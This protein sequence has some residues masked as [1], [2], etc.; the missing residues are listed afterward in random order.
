MDKKSEVTRLLVAWSDGDEAAFDRLM[1]V[2]EDELRK[3]ARRQMAGERADHTLETMALVNEM[4]LRLLDRRSLT[5]KNSAQFRA[6]AANT[7]KRVL[8]D[9][10]RR[11]QARMRNEGVKPLPI[12]E[13]RGI[14]AYRNG[15]LIELADGLHRLARVNERQ[16]QVIELHYF[17][18]LTCA[19]IGED[20]GFSKATA[21]RALTAGRAWLRRE[22][23]PQ[24]PA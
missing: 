6:F 13:I 7:M 23:R 21:K 18:G 8:V 17:G 16:A 19:Q 5:W 24:E 20:L 10:A 9:H 14:P 4:C 11:Y 22:M 1:V 2:L 15:E 3:I 12:D